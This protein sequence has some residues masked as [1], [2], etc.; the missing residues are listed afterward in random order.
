MIITIDDPDKYDIETIR[1]ESDKEGYNIINRLITDYRS[2]QNR[3]DKKG[4]KLVG[5]TRNDETVAICGLN[6]EPTDQ[7]LGRIR[8]L[9][10]SAEFRH[11]GIG[12]ELVKHLIEYAGQH[13][14]GVVVNIGDLPIGDFYQ[15]IGFSPVADNSSY[16]HIYRSVQ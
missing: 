4:E 9:Y 10:V 2:G 11:L 16:T 6:I 12:T 14:E 5:F 13:F 1:Y 7:K 8:R 3:F 15:S